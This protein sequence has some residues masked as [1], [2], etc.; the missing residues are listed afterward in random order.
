MP[1]AAPQIT[2]VKSG[3]TELS[4]LDVSGAKLPRGK[5]RADDPADAAKPGEPPVAE[6]GA[7]A[8]EP[9]TPPRK[10]RKLKSSSTF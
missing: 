3:A 1:G 4:P 8:A 6:A 5:R 7:R 9:P 10:W 2:P